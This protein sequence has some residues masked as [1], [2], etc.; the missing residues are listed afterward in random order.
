MLLLA[1]GAA[2]VAGWRWRRNRAA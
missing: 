2:A 1:S